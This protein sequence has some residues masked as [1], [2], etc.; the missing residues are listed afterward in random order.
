VSRKQPPGRAWPAWTL[1]A[2]L[3]V[4]G[5]ASLREA[6]HQQ[7][8]YR[9][10][11]RVE[12]PPD[13]EERQLP[14]LRSDGRYQSRVIVSGSF[15][16][17]YDGV[18][19]DAL[20]GLTQWG[21]A[22]PHGCLEVSPSVLTPV[23]SEARSGRRVFTPD[24]QMD[25]AGQPVRVRLD[26][27]RLTQDMYLPEGEDAPAFEGSLTVEVWERDR[28]A[29]TGAAGGL[30][31]LGVLLLSA[32]AVRV[33]RQWPRRRLRLRLAR[34]SELARQMDR[35][36]QR[37]EEALAALSRSAL[38]EASLKA[39]L[40]ALDAAAQ[41]LAVIAEAH[42]R[43]AGDLF[44][45][46]A[47]PGSEDRTRAASPAAQ[48]AWARVE[49]ARQEARRGYEEHLLAL[50]QIEMTFAAFPARLARVLRN[51]V[52]ETEVLTQVLHRELEG[53]EEAAQTV[54]VL[55]G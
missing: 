25:A 34:G 19:Y 45:G 4:S 8:A 14:P 38:P 30:G 21:E 24:P 29:Q 26:L 7:G 52:E 22:H 40:L 11:A 9:P 35:L 10:R 36:R 12:L 17:R 37:R 31:L 28:W 42:G 51:P 43:A 48:A 41:E 46:A 18:R 3:L 53:V 2:L 55:G 27:T 49:E 1:T 39:S 16:G 32:G 23:E 44:Q 54:R 33:R 20:E 15:R 50:Q 47:A 13:G 6:A 5:G